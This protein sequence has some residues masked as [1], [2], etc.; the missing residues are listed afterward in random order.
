VFAIASSLSRAGF[1]GRDN[2]CPILV[3]VDKEYHQVTPGICLSNR[4]VKIFTANVPSFNE[5]E[6]R[7]IGE[8]LF[9]LVSAHAVFTLDLLNKLREPDDLS[10]FHL[11]NPPR[12]AQGGDAEREIQAAEEGALRA[13]DAAE[14]AV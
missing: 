13:E 1:A 6:A 14:H 5:P 7:A 9:D 4:P 8:N 12:D 10:N 2:Q 3:L 11:I